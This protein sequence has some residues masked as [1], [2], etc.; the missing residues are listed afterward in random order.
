MS[1]SI[2]QRGHYLLAAG[3][4]CG[5]GLALAG[6]WTLAASGLAPDYRGFFLGQAVMADERSRIEDNEPQ[7]SE[8]STPEATNTDNQPQ[9]PRAV[10]AR[11]SAASHQT[12]RHGPRPGLELIDH[13]EIIR[14]VLLTTE[15]LHILVS[16]TNGRGRP[17]HY[18][19]VPTGRQWR[20]QSIGLEQLRQLSERQL[21]GNHQILTEARTHA[22]RFLAQMNEDFQSISLR[23]SRPADQRLLA[24]Q[25]AAIE[26]AGLDQNAAADGRY[27]TLGRLVQ[28]DQGL[29][30]QVLMVAQ[31]QQRIE[32]PE[33]EQPCY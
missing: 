18:R 24:R 13:L 1:H 9:G 20:A 15:D 19:L 31:G 14:P 28:C 26:A 30:L 16:A 7:Q 5:I 8:E 10:A 6:Y 3:L 29:D 12:Q 2:I 25:H 17:L 33:P 32:L 11:S 27:T 23:L 22:E 4:M 21:N